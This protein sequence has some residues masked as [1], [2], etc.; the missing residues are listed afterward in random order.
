MKRYLLMIMILSMPFLL[1]GCIFQEWICEGVWKDD[2]CWKDAAERWDKEDYCDKIEKPGPHSKCWMMLAKK[3]QN[4]EFCENMKTG[5]GAYDKQQCWMLIA[6]AQEN[7]KLCDKIGSY[8][9]SGN[10]VNPGGISKEKCLDKV[11]GKCGM[12]NGRCC[13]DEICDHGLVCKKENWRCVRTQSGALGQPCFM[14]STNSWKQCNEGLVCSITNT[15]IAAC[16]GTGQPCC[17]PAAKDIGSK[18][19][20]VANDPVLIV[21]ECENNVCV[22]KVIG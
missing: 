14:D 22:Q 16:G 2:H 8:T 12:E 7:T 11:F 10:D 19:Y 4:I 17:D 1:S 13:K 21:G 6:I 18:C 5:S 3:Q 9:H 20:T 15:C